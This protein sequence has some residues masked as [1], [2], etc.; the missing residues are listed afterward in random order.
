MALPTV[1]SETTFMFS[2]EGQSITSEDMHGHVN[3]QF[4]VSARAG[5]GREEE[6]TGEANPGRMQLYNAFLSRWSNRFHSIC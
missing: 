5:G 4:D 1:Q 3:T 6:V 2:H